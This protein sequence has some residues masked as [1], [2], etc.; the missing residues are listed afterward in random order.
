MHSFDGWESFLKAHFTLGLGQV[1]MMILW[2]ALPNLS[3]LQ[4]CLITK[5][6]LSLYQIELKGYLNHTGFV[7]S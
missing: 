6:S 2:N 1:L 7:V 4:L 3:K 5:L